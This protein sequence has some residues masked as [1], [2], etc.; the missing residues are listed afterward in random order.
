M[1]AAM[2][3]ICN[4]VPRLSTRARMWVFPL[5]GVRRTWAHLSTK[6]GA[7]PI[8]PHPG[9]RDRT[10]EPQ[11]G[12][13]LGGHRFA[14]Q[15]RPLRLTAAAFRSHRARPFTTQHR[16]TPTETDRNLLLRAWE[17][18]SNDAR[19]DKSKVPETEVQP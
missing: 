9:H 18:W 8:R 6:A 3:S 19:S 12:V 16:L 4:W 2:T 1:P 15:R 11:Q 13:R 14:S 17:L 7:L 10:I 5:S